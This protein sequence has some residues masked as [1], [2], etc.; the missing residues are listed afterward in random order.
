MLKI[1]RKD[2]D[3]ENLKCLLSEV[4]KDVL[5]SFENSAEAKVFFEI[6]FVYEFK[7]PKFAKLLLFRHFIKLKS[8]EF[9]SIDFCKIEKNCT[10]LGINGSINICRI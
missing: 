5:E 1:F 8:M 4:K 6:C 7:Y 3:L 10:M 9:M 2:V